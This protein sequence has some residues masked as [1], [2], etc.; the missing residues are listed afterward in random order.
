MHFH[1]NPVTGIQIGYGA[2]TA[3]IKGTLATA[4]GITTAGPTVRL[5]NPTTA[6]SIKFPCNL[7]LNVIAMIV[8]TIYWSDIAF[9]AITAGAANM[10]A[11]YHTINEQ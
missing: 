8:G 1:R 3:P 7:T 5:I 10:D 2:G 4:G 6:G 11:V 9:N